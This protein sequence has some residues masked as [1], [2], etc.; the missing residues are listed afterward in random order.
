MDF[1]GAIHTMIG[2]QKVRR[3]AWDGGISI[4][5]QKPDVHSKMT[6]PYFYRQ[7]GELDQGKTVPWIPSYEDMLA[8]DWEY[9]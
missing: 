9:A 1:G 8:D 4:H 3:S 7:Q 2:G 6:E 5:I